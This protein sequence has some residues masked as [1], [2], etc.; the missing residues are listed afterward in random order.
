MEHFA[1]RNGVSRV[2]GFS[3]SLNFPTINAVQA[4]R[5]GP[6]RNLFVARLAAAQPGLV[7]STCLGGSAIGSA[8]V[9]VESS[10]FAYVVGAA[11]ESL[12]V[13]N[14]LQS[15]PRSAFADAF[16]SKMTQRR[17]GR[18]RH[19]IG[20][21]GRG[22]PPVDHR[23]VRNGSGDGLLHIGRRILRHDDD[24]RGADAD[25]LRLRDGHRTHRI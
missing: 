3:E 16:I 9:A 17:G 14:A 21:F 6:G 5:G 20:R 11:P 8:E 10:G 7:Y 19:S 15:V 23:A 4:T 18:E 22:S 13:V 2:S 24:R 1:A 12:P 25:L